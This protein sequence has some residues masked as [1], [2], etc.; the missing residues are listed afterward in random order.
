MFAVVA[1][2]ADPA[3]PLSCLY[4]GEWPEPEVPYGWTT[5]SVRAASL[6][7]HDLWTLRG[8]GPPT[9]RM[10][11]VLGSD[12]AGIDEDGNEVV[13]HSVIG[14]PGAGR[15]DE[16]LDPRRALLGEEHHGTFAERVAVPR[17][18]LV[19]KPAGLSFEA[20]ACLPGAWL[21]AYRMLFGASG[22]A[23]GDTVL[24]QGAGGGVSTALIA[25][26]AVAGFRVWVTSRSA[27][28]RGRA[29]EIGAH[30]AFPVG[31][32]LPERVDAVMET[33]GEATWAHSLRS[34]RPGG[35]IV[36]SGA[37]TGGMPPAD[38]HHVFFRQLTIVGSTLGTLADLHALSRLCATHGIAPLVD[39]VLP[40]DR[41]REGFEALEGGG[42]FG[43]V[44]F[45]PPSAAGADRG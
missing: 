16:T 30:A 25:L 41:A 37:T 20:A 33:V 23:P 39:R 35:R 24:V 36:I 15:G 8:V 18:N 22:L 32:R 6:N 29:V 40:L 42:V 5:V 9:R 17:R 12:A 44:V 3:D 38:L 26:G 45:T 13:V 28:R 1:K 10:P 21:T 19:P 31:E 34:T 7:Q 4:T 14:D 2:G 11:V 27:E 43:K